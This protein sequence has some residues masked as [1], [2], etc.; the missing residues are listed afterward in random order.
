M[1]PSFQTIGRLAALMLLLVINGCSDSPTDLATD[2]SK[3]DHPEI[4]AS[5][6]GAVNAEVSGAGIVTYLPRKERD[7]VTGI[8][9]GYFLIANL[10]P[11]RTEERGFIITF[12]IPDEAQPGNYNLV[13][14]D[15]LKMGENFEVEVETV[16]EG[17]SILYQTN[18]KGTITLDHFSPDRTDPDIGNITG[19]FQFVTENSEGKQISANGTF[20]F[21]L[22]RK[23]LSQDTGYSFKDV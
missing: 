13:T 5:V 6:S 23:V 11:N 16:E 7:P 9:P 12:R 17:K 10:N 21:S 20:D 18:T 15:P 2:E 1:T 8:R 3:V 19:T 14:P 4:T 22:K